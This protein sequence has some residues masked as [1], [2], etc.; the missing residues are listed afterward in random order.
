MKGLSAITIAV[1][2]A[3]TSSVAVAAPK[4]SAKSQTVAS[5][6]AVSGATIASPALSSPTATA[7]SAG[8]IGA[9]LP[10]A[11]AKKWSVD[12]YSEGYYGVRAMNTNGG[13]SIASASFVGANYKL[14]DKYKAYVRQNFGGAIAADD[15]ADT[16]MQVEDTEVALKIANLAKW[17]GGSLSLSNRLYLPTGRTSQATDQ[18]ARLRENLVLSHELSKYFE[19]GHVTDPR[20]TF[21][22]KN[23]YRID[24]K[25]KKTSDVKLV[26]Y[27]YATAK[28]NDILSAT[29]ALG[30]IDSWQRANGEQSSQGY[31]DIA[32]SAQLTKQIGLTIGVDSEPN[33]GHKQEKRFSFMRDTETEY[34]MNVMASM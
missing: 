34:Y 13:G 32:A 27:A 15:Q 19:V 22:T 2:V 3:V 1:A 21:N 33:I 11:P 20:Y 29:V 24:G 18:V 16:R 5:T 28:A 6:S 17:N 14:S 7:T 9:T 10:T 8:S 26:Q 4:K 31:L 25:V 30:T 23:E 12:L